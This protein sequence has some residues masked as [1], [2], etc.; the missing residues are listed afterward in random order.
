MRSLRPTR[1]QV[2]MRVPAVF[3]IGVGGT[4]ERAIATRERV[5][6]RGVV[7]II[8]VAGVTMIAVDMGSTMFELSAD[9]FG[10]VSTI[11]VRGVDQSGGGLKQCRVGFDQFGHSRSTIWARIG[12]ISA[13]FDRLLGVFDHSCSQLDP[14]FGPGSTPKLGTTRLHLARVCEIRARVDQSSSWPD[15][16]QSRFDRMPTPLNPKIGPEFGRPMSSSEP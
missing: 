8:V 16:V 3:D 4:T 11:F 2:Q 9:N 14:R 13:G 7:P 1:M 6:V 10:P 12:Q 5:L 15:Q